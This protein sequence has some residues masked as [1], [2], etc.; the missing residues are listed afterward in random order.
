MNTLLK[1]AISL[2]AISLLG[3]CTMMAPKSTANMPTTTTPAASVASNMS[4][5]AYDRMAPAPYTCTNNTQVMAKQSINK[6][7][8]MINVTAPNLNWNQQPIVL[9][10]GVEGNTASYVNESN[11][12]VIYAW[13][14]QG[15]EG[16]LAMK[17]ADGK[18]YQV[19][20]KV[21]R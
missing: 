13:H 12:E 8:A 18:T 4:D 19:N 5:A 14:M 17:W 15:N 20:C 9:V 7:Q 11:P 21:G 16:V 6:N 10:G 1:L 2:P 3:A